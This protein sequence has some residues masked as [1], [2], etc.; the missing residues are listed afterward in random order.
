MD[1]LEYEIDGSPAALLLFK[2]LAR[3]GEST[4]HECDSAGLE[5]QLA[6]SADPAAWLLENARLRNGRRG[7]RAFVGA[8]A[9]TRPAIGFD[10]FSAHVI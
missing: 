4:D 8:L 1:R 3:E 2:R 9:K 5:P 6:P 10:V 7:R